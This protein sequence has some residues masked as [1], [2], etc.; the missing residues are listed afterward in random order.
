MDN[1]QKF[2]SDC[3]K[4]VEL[5]KQERKLKAEIEALKGSIVNLMAEAGTNELVRGKFCAKLVTSD[6]RTLQADKV[7]EIFGITLTPECY[8][9][10]PRQTL[11]VSEV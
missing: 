7:E 4:Y 10:S 5:K 1:G 6:Y 2:T 11:R 8:K 9:N 3:V